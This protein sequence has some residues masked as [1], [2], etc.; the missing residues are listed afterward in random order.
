MDSSKIW[1]NEKYFFCFFV[2]HLSCKLEKMKNIFFDFFLPKILD[3]ILEFH[4]EGPSQDLWVYGQKPK[5]RVFASLR[6]LR[7]R[8]VRS[9]NLSSRWNLGRNVQFVH[10]IPLWSTLKWLKMRSKMAI[11]GFFRFWPKMGLFPYVVFLELKSAR[12]AL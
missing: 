3:F 7:W 9:W 6:S 11:F 1:K 4:I 10:Q 12:R 5:N 2:P 8:R